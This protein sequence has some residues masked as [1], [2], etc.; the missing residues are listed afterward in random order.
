MEVNSAS[1]V[2]FKQQIYKLKP[3][4]D[5]SNSPV[6]SLTPEP[7]ES[8]SFSKRPSSSSTSET[9]R[10]IKKIGKGDPVRMSKRKQD[11][12]P[13]ATVQSPD[14][15][16]RS[17]QTS[18][19]RSSS[20][21]IPQSSKPRIYDQNGHY[22]AEIDFDRNVDTLLGRILEAFDQRSPAAILDDLDIMASPEWIMEY[23]ESALLRFGFEL[24]AAQVRFGFED[25]ARIFDQ[26]YSPATRAFV[27]GAWGRYRGCDLQSLFDN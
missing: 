1:K 26:E 3:P 11:L 20:P 16:A 21:V 13:N 19:S 8:L 23:L 12:E 15:V 9:N 22:A 2:P 10:Q 4:A 24:T 25:S 5:S 6:P 14:P 17:S 7:D 27:A 18:P